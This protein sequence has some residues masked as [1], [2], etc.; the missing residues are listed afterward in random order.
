MKIQEALDRYS[1]SCKRRKLSLESTKTYDTTLKNFSKWLTENDVDVNETDIK[2]L[3]RSTIKEYLL[4]LQSEM[5]T[6]TVQ[7]RHGVLK[8]LYTWMIEDEEYLDYNIPKSI[9]MKYKHEDIKQPIVTVDDM[10]KFKAYFESVPFAQRRFY[11]YRD[12]LMIE[13]L[14]SCGMRVGEL[15][16]LRLSTYNQTDCSF[17]VLAKGSKTRKMYI[18]NSST[19]KIMERY[20]G[21]RKKESDYLFLTN[22]GNPSHEVFVAGVINRLCNKSGITKHL[23]PHSFRRGCATNLVEHGVDISHVQQVLG[24]SHIA[25]TMKYVRLSDKTVENVMKYHNPLDNI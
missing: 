7:T 16:K 17:T 23:T 15:S 2:E 25:T 12:R 13:M 4:S 22:H 19:R 5:S 24:H 3:D 11:Y 21:W 14:Y 1:R 20:L 10:K 18:A 6:K 9:K 8:S